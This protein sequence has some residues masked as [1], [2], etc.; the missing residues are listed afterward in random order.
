VWDPR[1]DLLIAATV[2]VFVFPLRMPITGYM[3][4]IAIEARRR[5]E[6]RQAAGATEVATS[7]AIRQAVRQPSAFL[8]LLNQVGFSARRNRPYVQTGIH[9]PRKTIRSEHST[10]TD[11]QT[12]PVQR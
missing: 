3:A 7:L 5:G 9:T 11:A 12:I 1:W 6:H 10:Q 4:G 8:R 2:G